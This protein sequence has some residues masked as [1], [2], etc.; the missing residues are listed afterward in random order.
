MVLSQFWGVVVVV[1][2]KKS[3]QPNH[4]KPK[5]EQIVVH[6]SSGGDMECTVVP[7]LG[8]GFVSTNSI[9]C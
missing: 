8:L 6:L 4:R 2:F 3:K 1:V 9:L 7:M 5:P